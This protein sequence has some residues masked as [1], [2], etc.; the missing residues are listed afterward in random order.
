MGKAIAVKSEIGATKTFIDGNELGS[1][2]TCESGEDE[3]SILDGFTITPGYATYGGGM[4]NYG[5]NPTVTNSILWDNDALAG[6]EIWIGIPAAPSTLSIRHSDV[7]GGQSSVHV[8]GGTLAWGPG[9]MDVDPLF[10]DSTNGDLHLTCPSP[11]RDTGNNSDV[12][13]INDFEGDPRIVNGTVDMGADEFH[14]HLYQTGDATPGGTV[15][16]KLVGKPDTNPVFLWVG[17]GVMGAPISTQYGDW[18]L[19]LPILLTLN[20]GS[21]ASPERMSVMAYTVDSAFPAIDIPMQS[22]IGH[23]LTNLC[24]M[25]V[26]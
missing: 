8:N 24:V 6:P 26:E 18:Y 10:V 23:D 12:T 16:I 21:I 17:S 22:L 1:A 15:E 20:L 25:K 7:K 9:M 13:E 3:N 14:T 4:Y 11:C 19:D 5:S 2:V